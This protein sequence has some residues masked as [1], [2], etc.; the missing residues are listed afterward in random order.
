ML[1]TNIIDYCID[2]E[3]FLIHEHIHIPDYPEKAN[4]PFKIGE[5]SLIYDCN[6]CPAIFTIGLLASLDWEIYE[7]K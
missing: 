1:L 6:D 4:F 2:P 3:G 5:D 7:D